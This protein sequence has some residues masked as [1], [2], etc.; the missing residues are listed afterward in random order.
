L[1]RRS[2]HEW[3]LPT[4]WC[5]PGRRS[6]RGI[7]HSTDRFEIVLRE[8]EIPFEYQVGSNVKH[9]LGV[10]L[11]LV[12]PANN[13]AVFAKLEKFFDIYYSTKQ[14]FFTASAN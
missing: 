7:W 14:D 5:E 13:Q 3:S 1:Q 6:A 2:K 11:G 12:W 4:N 10:G 9:V 8:N